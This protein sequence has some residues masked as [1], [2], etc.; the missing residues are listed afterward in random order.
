MDLA[1][2]AGVSRTRFPERFDTFWAS[3]H[4]GIFRIRGAD[5]PADRSTQ[6]RWGR[7]APAGVVRDA[8][9]M[10]YKRFISQGKSLQAIEFRATAGQDFSRT[11]L[12][13][14]SK[15]HGHSL[16]KV[17]WFCILWMAVLKDS[18]ASFAFGRFFASLVKT[19]MSI[20]E[21]LAHPNPRNDRVPGINREKMP[22]VFSVVK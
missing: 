2:H 10:H 22:R 1:H 13:S 14:V 12:Q 4:R 6:R 3:L 20:M 7:F 21:L 17:C 9:N 19:R 15:R 18:G 8:L 16:I 11:Q 5:F